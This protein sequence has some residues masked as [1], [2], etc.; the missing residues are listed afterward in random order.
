MIPTNSGQAYRCDRF[1]VATN[2][3]CGRGIRDVF[4]VCRVETYTAG[5]QKD[6]EGHLVRNCPALSLPSLVSINGN[7]GPGRSRDGN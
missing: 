4:D 1:G 6:R 3:L 7:S 2:L 5:L